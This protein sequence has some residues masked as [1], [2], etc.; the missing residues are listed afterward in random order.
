MEPICPV[1]TARLDARSWPAVVGL[2]TQ[3]QAQV[4][5]QVKPQAKVVLFRTSLQ[6]QPTRWFLQTCLKEAPRG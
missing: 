6:S 4:Q 1:V 3:V 5:A 2:K